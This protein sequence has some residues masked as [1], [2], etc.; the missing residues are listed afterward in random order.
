[1]AFCE[2]CG[3]ELAD[4]EQCTCTTAE[5]VAQE[6]VT[7][8]S[9]AEAP[10]A[11][12]APKAEAAP[13][14]P[15]APAKAAAPKKNNMIIIGVVA[16]VVVVLLLLVVLLAGG[17]KGYMSP[18]DDFMKQINKKNTDVVEVYTTLMPDFAADLYA[19]THK[20]Y[21][22]AEDYADYY[23]DAIETME[24]Y[25]EDCDDEF[26]KWKLS[27]ETKKASELDEDDLEDIQDYLD[28]YYDDYR[29]ADVDTYEDL[30]DDDDDLE[31]SADELDISESQVKAILKA[32]MKYAQAY[33]EM[34]VTAGYEVKGKF[35]VKSGKDTY[36][37]KNVEF[38]VVKINGDWTYWGLVDGSLDFEDDDENCF[39]FL[40][41]FL[42]SRRLY[43]SIIF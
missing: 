32:S 43:K 33:E 9:V 42:S 17:S 36:E 19:Q 7:E 22:V 29:E 18:V 8:A 2:N 1:M 10:V 11:E 25:Y 28:D 26:D 37:T 21:M 39:D 24:D 3:K 31:D 13:E 40:S 20:K 12:E 16:A 35:I 30:L 15:E 41:N 4:G 34:K 5:A 14:A 38:R 23:E 6:Q 27:F